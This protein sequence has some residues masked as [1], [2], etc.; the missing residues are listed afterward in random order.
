VVASARDFTFDSLVSSFSHVQPIL[1]ADKAAAAGR[2][3]YDDEYF[4]AF[5]AAAK[6][7]L[8]DRLAAAITATASLIASAWQ[9]AGRPALAVE[10]ARTARK[11]RRQ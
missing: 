11:I 5:F 8:E 1:D 7:I 4:T 6:P 2:E 10:Q 9:Q 3:L